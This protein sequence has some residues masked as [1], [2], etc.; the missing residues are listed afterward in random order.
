MIRIRFFVAALAFALVPF[1]ICAPVKASG[2]L[3]P[4]DEYFGH[5]AMSVLGIAN[6]LRDAPARFSDS[7]NRSSNID[8]PLSFVSDAIHAWERKYPNDPWI[9][10]DLYALEIV[11]LHAPAPRALALAM[12]TQA[13]LAHDY[14]GSTYIVPSRVALENVRGASGS[15]PQSSAWARFTS[16]R[17]PLRTPQ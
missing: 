4:A 14:P 13:W 8:G 15:Y 5:Y 17:A 9:A 12:L 6:I 11:Y 10:K 1:L 3:A 16:A 7:A 2:R